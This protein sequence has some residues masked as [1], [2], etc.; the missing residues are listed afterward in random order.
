MSE[1]NT[2][3]VSTVNLGGGAPSNLH[4]PPCPPP[5]RKKLHLLISRASIF[6]IFNKPLIF[7]PGSQD[8]SRLSSGGTGFSLNRLQGVRGR[9]CP[10]P[11][12]FFGVG[13]GCCLRFS[14]SPVHLLDAGFVWLGQLKFELLGTF[15]GSCSEEFPYLESDVGDKTPP[16]C[17]HLPIIAE[18]GDLHEDVVVVISSGK[19]TRETQVLAVLLS[20]F[21]HLQEFGRRPCACLSPEVGSTS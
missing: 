17:V 14:P 19:S 20:T 21:Q 4:S 10:T 2:F 12:F 18:S 6:H 13:G 7:F 1:Q 5:P 15:S 11:E 16:P 8:K 9:R 3:Q